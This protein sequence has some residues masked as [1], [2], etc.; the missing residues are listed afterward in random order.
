MIYRWAATDPFERDTRGTQEGHKR[1][2]RGTQGSAVCIH[3]QE[4]RPLI[5]TDPEAAA[6]HPFFDYLSWELARWT[7]SCLGRIALA[8]QLLAERR[9]DHVSPASMLSMSQTADHE[10]DSHILHAVASFRYADTP[11]AHHAGHTPHRTSHAHTC[12]CELAS[13]HEGG[14]TCTCEL[15]SLPRACVRV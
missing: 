1:D 8:P 12:T 14:H 2:T 4:D 7:P 10:I 9:R 5:Q 15:A 6:K 11:R 3:G 13:P